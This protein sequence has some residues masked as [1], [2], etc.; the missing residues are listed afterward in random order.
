MAKSV[1]N[2]ANSIARI[3]KASKAIMSGKLDAAQRRSARATVASNISMMRRMGDIP[4]KPNR[5]HV[6]PVE[7]N[8]RLYQELQDM[9]NRLKELDHEHDQPDHD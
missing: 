8:T 5:F 2:A 1:Y 7:Q 4:P 3:E 9:V 6:V